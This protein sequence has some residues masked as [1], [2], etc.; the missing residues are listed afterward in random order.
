MTKKC[1]SKFLVLY[2]RTCKM[3]VEHLSALEAQT[4]MVHIVPEQVLV[5]DIQAIASPP[6]ISPTSAPDISPTSAP[7]VPQP[8]AAEP[9]EFK[10]SAS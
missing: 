7:D 8:Q 4:V 5:A 1:L 9:L 10:S 2:C 3:L 6:D